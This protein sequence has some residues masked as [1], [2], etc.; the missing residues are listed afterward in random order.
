MNR[1]YRH[2]SVGLPFLIDAKALAK[3]REV[4]VEVR[5][6]ADDVSVHNNRHP[7]SLGDPLNLLM[8]R[9]PVAMVA[10]VAVERT[11][12]L[13]ALRVDFSARSTRPMSWPAA[14]AGA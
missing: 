13:I 10:E 6:V 9:V 8:P 2:N 11:A 5:G 3:E 7:G 4:A 1:R 12:N 14:K